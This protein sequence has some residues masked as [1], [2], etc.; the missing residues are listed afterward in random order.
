M[1]SSSLFY[2]LAI[3]SA[4]TRVSLTLGQLDTKLFRAAQ[5]IVNGKYIK[6]SNVS[7]EIDVAQEVKR[8]I[9]GLKSRWLDVTKRDSPSTSVSNW[10]TWLQRKMRPNEK[11]KA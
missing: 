8:N 4:L 6:V 7:T 3:V 1:P 9:E 11:S 5:V 10:S 2:E